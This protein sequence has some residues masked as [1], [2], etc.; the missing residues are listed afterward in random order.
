MDLYEQQIL[1]GLKQGRENA[2]EMVF[3]TYYQPLCRYAY[4]FLNDRDEAEEVVQAAFIAVWDKRQKLS[5]EASLKS[6]LFRMVRNS[7]LNV[8]KHNKVRQ[9]YAAE[10]LSFGEPVAET[11]SQSILAVELE[12]KI[13]DSLNDLPDQCRLVFQLSRFEELKYAEIAAQLNISLKTV[14]N[15]MGKALKILRTKLKD[16]LPVF[17]LLMNQWLTNG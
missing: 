16:Y 15:H 5:I 7:C 10:S 8:I 12:K 6:Y 17:L 11:T 13:S 9:L 4:T 3:R 1:E 2:L 14:E